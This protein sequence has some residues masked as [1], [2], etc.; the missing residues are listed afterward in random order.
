MRDSRKMDIDDINTF[1][2]S[3]NKL[4]NLCGSKYY[5]NFAS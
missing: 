3:K 2:K 5:C 1:F 4:N